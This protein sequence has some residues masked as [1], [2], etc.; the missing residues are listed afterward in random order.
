[1]LGPLQFLK[2]IRRSS[3]KT[4]RVIGYIYY[5]M[6]YPASAGA[7]WL[8]FYAYSGL[9]ALL[10]F[11]C[12]AAGW[13]ITGYLAFVAIKEKRIQDH[14]NW[15]LRNYALTYAAVT[16][17]I[18][19][20]INMAFNG[21]RPTEAGYAVISWMCWVVNVIIMEV[22]IRFVEHRSLPAGQRSS[23]LKPGP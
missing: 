3:A 22:W 9:P 21:G 8:A 23:Q 2:T 13:I 18:M 17:R 10:G 7:F 5:L 12:L 19:L 6:L 1:M 11:A 15:M 14:K 20:P 16:L 4:H